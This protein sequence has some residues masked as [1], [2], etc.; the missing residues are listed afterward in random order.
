MGEV[1]H[2]VAE[3]PRGFATNVV[4]KR[5]RPEFATDS[6]FIAMLAAE[7]RVCARLDHPGIV[8]VYEFGEVE[9]EHY[10]AM[11]LVDGWDLHEILAGFERAGRLPPV[12]FLSYVGAELADALAY[13]HALTDDHGHPLGFVHRDVSPGNVMINRQ[14][15]VKLVDFGVHTIRDHSAEERT[16]VGVL[17]GTLAYMS[18][19]QA[20]GQP[21]DHRSDVFS[22]GSVLYEALTG[23]RL[24]RTPN[25]LETLR[26]VREAVVP[27]PSSHRGDLDPR[28]DRIVLSMMARSPADRTPSCD[29]VSRAL[30]PFA[31]EAGVDAAW[32]RALLASLDLEGADKLRSVER[33]ETQPLMPA[34]PPGRAVWLWAALVTAA[35]A[36][37]YAIPA[38]NAPQPTHAA[39]VTPDAAERK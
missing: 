20:D 33:R 39:P 18:P 34:A 25:D 9:G 22:L 17:R 3:G 30:R 24:F 19:E 6:K 27:P 11:E 5:V 29:E 35:I 8:K 2:A 23:Q 1:W 21:V 12:A 38:C 26:R 14:G 15:A 31:Q 36:S 32:V 7:A 4:L 28:L 10:L 37:P 16:A 13:A